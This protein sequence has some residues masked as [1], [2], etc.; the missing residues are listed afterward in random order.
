[1][2]YLLAG[3]VAIIAIWNIIGRRRYKVTWKAG[4]LPAKSLCC[5]A[6][7]QPIGWTA[8]GWVSSCRACGAWQYLGDDF[9]N[10][11]P[12]FQQRDAA[13]N[14]K[15]YAG[16]DDEVIPFK[17]YARGGLVDPSGPRVRVGELSQDCILGSPRLYRG[18]DLYARMSDNPADVLADLSGQPVNEETRQYLDAEVTSKSPHACRML[19]CDEPIV[20]LGLCQHHWD[21]LNAVE[22]LEEGE[23][24][25]SPPMPNV[26]GEGHPD[27]Q[28][29]HY[30][31][32]L[33]G[34]EPRYAPY[35]MLNEP[36][37]GTAVVSVGRTAFVPIEG[38][39]DEDTGIDKS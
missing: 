18:A 7:T 3:I 11:P 27:Y 29:P 5:A 2:I 19:D 12:G 6:P 9:D 14:S 34:Q 30:D 16:S 31:S 23:P 32:L 20:R 39:G 13:V 33:D 25:T 4:G 37:P 8:D 24:L 10:P 15:P 1:M 38:Q 28:G 22:R 17:G 26:G 21:W 36:I 35:E